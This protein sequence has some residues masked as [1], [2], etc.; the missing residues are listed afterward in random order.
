MAPVRNTLHINVEYFD[1]QDEGDTGYPYY[2]ASCEEIVAV[3][4]GRSWH[5]LMQNI[6]SMIEASLEDEDT[7]AVY[8]LGPN[9]RIVIMDEG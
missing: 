2:V 6:Q 8:N 5:E 3:T 1:G 9:P 7:V 4:D